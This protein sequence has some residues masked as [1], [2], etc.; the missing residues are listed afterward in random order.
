MEAIK[1]SHCKK[2]IKYKNN[3]CKPQICPFCQNKYSLKPF[4]EYKLFCLQAE[5]LK[6][7]TNKKVSNEFFTILDKY[8]NR[9]ILKKLKIKKLSYTKNVIREKINYTIYKLYIYYQKPQFKIEG[10]FA[11]YINQVLLDTFYNRKRRREEGHDS[12]N[13]KINEEKNEIIDNIFFYGYHTLS[14]IEVDVEAEILKKD[15][16]IVTELYDIVHYIFNNIQKLENKKSSYLYLLGI[17]YFFNK[18]PDLYLNKFYNLAGTTLSI[19]LRKSETVLYDYL[20]RSILTKK[21]YIVGKKQIIENPDFLWQKQ[22]NELFKFREET[23]VD[24]FFYIVQLILSFSIKNK[25]L[26]E[27]YK[28]LG[29]DNFTKM[30][31]FFDGK[32]IKL[33]K[34]LEFKETMLLA[35]FYY[36]RNIEKKSWDDIKKEVPFDVE[37]IKYGI[38]MKKLN[39]FIKQEIEKLFVDL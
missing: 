11:G 10:S 34:S 13:Q 26:L 15:K 29:L 23:D 30:I 21:V 1:C 14:N 19:Y 20:K 16:S 3:K 38:R 4:L 32:E 6:D 18:Q 5:F 2:V 39:N 27:M 25:D 31:N 24:K 28:L 22:I 37:S 7:K 12:L 33:L 36:L 9:L 8:I 35:L 17:Y